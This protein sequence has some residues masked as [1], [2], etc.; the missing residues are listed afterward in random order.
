MEQMPPIYYRVDYDKK[1]GIYTGYCPSM[2]P[3]HFSSKDEKEVDELVRDGI[4][5]YLEKHPDFFKSLKHL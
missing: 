3:V 2:K 5:L 1:T 4:A